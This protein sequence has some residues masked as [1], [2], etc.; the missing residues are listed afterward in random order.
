MWDLDQVLRAPPPLRVRLTRAAGVAAV[1]G[2]SALPVL[3]GLQ[4]CAVAAT[5]HRPCPGCGMTRALKLLAHGDVQGSLRM[6]AFAV[7]ILVVGLLLV[8]ST[9]WA[10]LATGSPLGLYRERSARV[11]LGLTVAAYGGAFVLWILRWFGLF[12]GPVA[13]Y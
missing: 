8:G 5:F 9:V 11:L 2:L 10:T 1:W 3:T 4:R 7:P 13:V 12:G 6:H